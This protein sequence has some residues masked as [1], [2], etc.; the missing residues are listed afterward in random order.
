MTKICMLAYTFYHSDPRVRREAEALAGRGDRVDFICVR[1][2]KHASETSL[3][4]VNL[5]PLKVSRYQGG[6]TFRY[7]IIYVS[8]LIRSAVL[9]TR[10]YL[11][12]RYDI[13]HVHTMP[14]FLVFAALIPKCLG[15]K[16]IL[17]VHDL[18]PELYTCKFGKADN[19]LV[20]LITWIERRSIAFAHRAIAVSVPHRNALVEHGNRLDHFSVVLNV[21]D[22]RI[23]SEV[24]ELPSRNEGPF[25]LVYHGTVAR[26]HGLEIALR[27]VA[28]LRGL[29]P[30]LE[31][32]VIGHGDDIERIKR[33]AQELKLDG[34]VRFQGRVPVDELPQYLRQADLGVIPLLYDEFTRYM[35]PLKLLEY[36]H[37]GIPAVV[38]RT[39]TI[40]TYF[41]DTMVRYIASGNVEQLAAAIL[42]LYHNPGDR[43]ALVENANKFNER[44]NWSAQ[45]EELFR[46]VDTL[47]GVSS[48]LKAEL[49]CQ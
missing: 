28:S 33:V 29:I 26:R 27:A 23:F 19:L 40:Q 14:D 2:T 35:L 17:D 48:P 10:L 46:I 25:R 3:Q 13:V 39:E 49:I 41:D 20:K 44:Y 12:N 6:S 32:L 45:K 38:T 42:E 9:L 31:F 36:V 22:P 24:L 18:M 11:K 30:R 5:Y 4:G 34:C 47:T 37:L 16:V 1:D 43:A 15:A 21:P 8:F 7:L